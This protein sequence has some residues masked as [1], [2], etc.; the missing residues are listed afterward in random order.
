V[1]IRAGI[2][3]AVMLAATAITTAFAQGAGADIYKT[4]C[5]S[6]HGAD[7]MASSGVGKILKV[8]PA[9]DAS[10][11]KM[12]ET[13]MIAAVQN[14]MGKMQPY[15]NSLTEAQIKGAVDYFRMF[16]K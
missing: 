11:K 2:T 13:E 10:V 4:K 12:S 3:T 14:G 1:K 6:C 9:N 8:K 5:Q 7:G 15:K 16:E